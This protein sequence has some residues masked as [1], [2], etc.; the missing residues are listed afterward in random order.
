MKNSTIRKLVN[1]TATLAAVMAATLSSSVWAQDA[2]PAGAA[3]SIGAYPPGP[4]GQ[5]TPMTPTPRPDPLPAFYDAKLPMPKRVEDL[6]SRLSLEEKVA[7]MQMASPAIPRL[8]IAP[9]HWWTEALHGMTHDTSTVFP[10]AIGLAAT[11]DTDLHFKVATAISTEGRAKNFEYRA[12]NVFNAMTGL[13]FWSPNINIFRDPRWGRG[14]E[15]YGEDPYLS[16]RFAIAFVKGIQGDDPMYFKAIA[17]PKHY[18]VHSGPEP[19]RHQFDAVVTDEDLYTTYLPQFE[20]AI[21]EAHAHSVMS[22][23]NAVNGVPNS[24]N[25]RLLTDILRTQWGFDGYVVGDDGSVADIYTSHRYAPDGITTSALAV[26]AGNDLDSGTTYAGG[27]GGGRNLANANLVK[28]VR[29]GL[30]T[31]K[32]IDVAVGRVMEARIRLGEFDPAG[33]PGNPYNAITTNMYNTEENHALALKAGRETMVLLKNANHTLPLK[34]GIGTVAVLGP[35]ANNFTMQ[36]GNYN[37]H[38]TPQ[39]QISILDGI[40]QAIGADHVMTT[41]NLRVPVTATLALAELVKADCLFS[42]ESKSKHGLTVTYHSTF[43]PGTAQATSG[44]AVAETGALKTPDATSSI[45]FE[46]AMGATMTGVLVPPATGE[47]QLGARGRDAFRLSV[48]G[49]VVI[50]EMQGGAMRTAGSAIHLEKD[51]AYKILVEFSHSSATT[52]GGGRGGRG[53]RGFGGAGAVFAPDGG[54]GGFGRGGRGGGGSFGATAENPGV[55]AASS[56]DTNL[57]FQLAWTMPAADG[58]AANTAGQSLYGEAMD[59]T[60]KADAVVV[61]VGIDGSQ[62]GEGRDRAAIELPAVQEGLIKAVTA[63]AG[64]KPVV[65]V[66]C[67][68]SAIALHGAAENAGAIVQAW[69]PGQRGDA[70]ADVLFG[71]YNPAGRLPVTFYKATTDLPAFTNYSMVN[72]T[73]RYFTKPV[74]Y[75]FGHGLS[76]STF[77]YSKLAV[78]TSAGTGDDVKVSVTVKNTSSVDGDEVVQ[79]YLNRDLPPVDAANLPDAA[80]MTDEQATLVAT[81]RKALV[82]FARVPLKAGESKQVTFT[83]TTQQLSLVVGKDGKREVRPGNLQIQV[84][85]SSVN[86]PGTLIQPLALTGPAVAPKYHFVAPVISL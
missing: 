2:P 29:Q 15:S 48:D 52:G 54:G 63:A 58:S 38:P 27:A 60:K 23:Y 61:V 33:Y 46:P 71:K 25:T 80:K 24:C 4:G 66:D 77:E 30:I 45:A 31:E 8:G 53:G 86:G 43:P 67:S 5:N 83:I 6:V 34:T 47:Y 70:V 81:P 68:G 11:W 64:T 65:V 69:Y 37:G 1:R 32:E 82:G 85:G 21:R 76:Y 55:T 72:R 57:L 41:T 18:A 7:L 9:Y 40:R 84:G 14:Q 62:E 35:N 59:L 42:D 20:A 51:K 39:H 3:S 44:G 73:Y 13:D 28:A 75:P 36:L 16:G 22:S 50:D 26:K 17:T 74:L 19:L 79:C 10:Q 56:T 49:S 78:P 12:K